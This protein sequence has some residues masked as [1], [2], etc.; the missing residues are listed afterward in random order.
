MDIDRTGVG[1][2]LGIIVPPVVSLPT[3]RIGDENKIAAARMIE[4]VL[5]NAFGGEDL[6]D[7]R[8]F[9]EQAGDLL[10]DFGIGVLDKNVRELVVG[11]SPGFAVGEIE[12]LPV[13]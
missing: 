11:E 5:S 9:G 10:D 7:P 6:G 3:V 4:L 13:V 2:R 1:G 12:M 8:V